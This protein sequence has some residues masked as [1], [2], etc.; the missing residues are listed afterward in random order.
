MSSET[1]T[2]PSQ[3]F[4]LLSMAAATVA[5]M[6]TGQTHPAALLML[7]AGVLACGLAA[8]FLH[9]ALF[10]LVQ[11]TRHED[12]VT[13]ERRALLVADKAR[14]LHS[15]KELEFDHKM[16]K[17]SLKD[18]QELATPLRLRAATLIEDLDR[19]DAEE[20][21]A[22]KST[23]TRDRACGACSTANDPDAKFCKNCGAPLGGGSRSRAASS[24]V[25][26]LAVILGASAASPAA[27]QI[28]MPNPKEI[29]GVPLPAAD[30][31]VGSVTVR[32][33]RGGWDKNIVGQPVEFVVAGKPRTVKTDEQGRAEVSG[34]A[35]GTLVKATAVVDKET[36]VSQDITVGTSGV[37]VVLVATDPDAAKRAEEDKKLA[38]GPAVPGTVVLGPNTRIM[39]EP[40]DEVVTLF[41][42]LDIVNSARSPVDLGGPL[43]LDLPQGA[44]GAGIMEGSSPQGKVLGAHLTVLGPFKPGSTEVQLAFE[45]PTGS[46]TKTI[47]QAF[48]V[49]VPEAT[50]LLQRVSGEDVTGAQLVDRR[51]TTNNGQPLVMARV[52][53]IGAGGTLT[54]DVTGLPHHPRWPRYLA[55]T[56]GLGFLLLGVRESF[57]RA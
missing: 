27:A 26:L 10:A 56:F 23:K 51:E 16:G 18:F 48:P 35:P 42:V 24:A 1:S 57:R 41:Y 53:A 36:L 21:A 28:A 50:L 37:R 25:V 31:K 8:Y 17:I 19:L 12:S 7:S 49:S 55:L 32:L 11:P 44:R 9:G 52:T 4:I 54:F 15:I 46:G 20:A 45:L 30:V 22:P 29:S 34:L 43:Q 14:V 2:K 40:G 5:V 3:V 13:G 33:I 39:V 6:M 38:A 47:E